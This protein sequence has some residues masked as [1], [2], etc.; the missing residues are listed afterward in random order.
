MTP[1]QSAKSA[2]YSQGSGFNAAVKPS[3]RTTSDPDETKPGAGSH[4]MEDPALTPIQG[5]EPKKC[6]GA[7]AA[8]ALL[9]ST[10]A[11][12]MYKAHIAVVKAQLVAGK[13]GWMLQPAHVQSLRSHKAGLV[14]L[15][16]MSY[17]PSVK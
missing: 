4:G 5:E 9:V 10:L 17:K 16:L 14:E 6:K 1:I 7:A 13:A 15:C 3:E 11:C 12:T 8:A 2:D